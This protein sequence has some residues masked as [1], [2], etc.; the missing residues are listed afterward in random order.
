[1]SEAL[2]VRTERYVR[3]DAFVPHVRAALAAYLDTYPSG[4]FT[5][6]GL[7]YIDLVSRERLN[8]KG[9]RWVELIKRSALGLLSEDEIPI[10]SV[11]ELKSATVLKLDPT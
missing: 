6:I 4:P 9:A 1:S 2:T 11:E 5:R 7:R 8:L 3:W 10:E